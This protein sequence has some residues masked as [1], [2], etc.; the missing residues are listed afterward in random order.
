MSYRDTEGP[1]ERS[2]DLYEHN[3][4]ACIDYNFSSLSNYHYIPESCTNV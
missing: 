1:R 4:E 2:S 3:Y